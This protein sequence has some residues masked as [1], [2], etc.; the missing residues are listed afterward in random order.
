MTEKG[1]SDLP[2]LIKLRKENTNNPNIAYFNINS[3]REKLISLQ[4]ICLKSSID[5]LCVNE[6]ELDA[7][8]PNAQFHIEGYQFPP[9]R[10]NRNKHSGGKMVFVRNGITA[11][12]LESLEGKESETICISKKKWCTMFT[13]RPPKNDS[14]VM[15]FNELNLSLNQCVNKY[16]NIIV[17]GDLNIDISDK[18]KDND[19]FLSDLCDTFSL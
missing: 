1:I 14:K 5:V 9:F 8:Y 2:G 4:E 11:K 18:R 12:R 7:S 10:R 6:T 17:M 13:Y 16:D 19:N 15:F 3:L